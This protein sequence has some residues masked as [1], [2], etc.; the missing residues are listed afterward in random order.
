MDKIP[1]LLFPII[2]EYLWHSEYRR[3]LSLFKSLEFRELKKK[4]VY[5]NLKG[6]YSEEFLSNELFR[7]ELLSRIV[8]KSNQ[9]SLYFDA[10]LKEPSIFLHARGVHTLILE[11]SVVYSH[12]GNITELSG[13]HTL[14][15]SEGNSDTESLEGL[16]DISSIRLNSFHGIADV[17]PLASLCSITLVFCCDLESVDCLGNVHSLC[18]EHCPRVNISGLGKNNYK[19]SLI[20]LPQVNDVGHLSKVHNLVIKECPISSVQ[21]LG[22]V[23]TLSLVDCGNLAVL[24]GLGSNNHS[25]RIQRCQV[26]TDFSPLKN[27]HKLL[28]DNCIGFIEGLHVSG[29][30]TLTI[31]Y[32]WNLV[33]LSG[34]ENVRVL[35]IEECKNLV[36]FGTSN[37]LNQRIKII[38]CKKLTD[39]SLLA[40]V[41]EVHFTRCYGITDLSCLKGC[42]KVEWFCPRSRLRKQGMQP[43]GLFELSNLV[44]MGNEDDYYFSS[45]DD[46][47]GEY[48]TDGFADAGGNSG[49]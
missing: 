29:V 7:N 49:T 8:D 39:V 11:D 12:F 41:D 24:D 25:V 4:T 22:T 42:R 33:I 30:K 36:N 14:E 1:V 47:A 6:E 13:I 9:I 2:K 21:G 15:I 34:V 32:L 17:S 16:T 28:I 27:C 19:L 46:S 10:D 20:E 31:R 18:I 35:I 45:D 26:I 40:S 38:H 43:L 48:N 5:Y 23:H 3:L 44:R 37:M